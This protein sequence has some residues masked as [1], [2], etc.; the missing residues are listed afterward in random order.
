MTLTINFV[1]EGAIWRNARKRIEYMFVV[2]D[3]E[4]A[5]QVPPFYR[6][7]IRVNLESLGWS[8]EVTLID[9]I[10]LR[11]LAKVEINPTTGLEG[12][13][14]PTEHLLVMRRG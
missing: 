13:R 9:T 3:E 8:H 6:R 5:K 1:V 12:E 10:V 7:K 2:D 4:V 11:R 14:T